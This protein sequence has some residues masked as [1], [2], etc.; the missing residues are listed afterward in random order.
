MAFRA[1]TL[2]LPVTPNFG[3][4]ATIA[5]V[6]PSAAVIFAGIEKE[7]TAVVTFAAACV[8]GELACGQELCSGTSNRAERLVEL[9]GFRMPLPLKVVAF[10]DEMQAI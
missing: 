6:A 9:V 2:L 5:H 1:A 10:T 4:V 8:A 7:P 3:A